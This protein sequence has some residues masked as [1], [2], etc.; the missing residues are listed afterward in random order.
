MGDFD[1]LIPSGG[2]AVLDA[3][4]GDDPFADLIPK[5]DDENPFGDLIPSQSSPAAQAAP[6]SPAPL[7]APAVRGV[8]DAGTSPTAVESEYEQHL[9][10]AEAGRAALFGPGSIVGGTLLAGQLNKERKAS[11]LKEAEDIAVQE[12]ERRAVEKVNENMG[13]GVLGELPQLDYP[14]ELAPVVTQEFETSAPLENAGRALL[15]GL[16]RGLP[17]IIGGG[18]GVIA[19]GEDEERRQIEQH[20]R[21]ML[22]LITK[23]DRTPFEER[24]L[25]SA[26]RRLVR[27]TSRLE[28]GAD[29]YAKLKEI[30][31]LAAETSKEAQTFFGQDPKRQEDFLTKF[32]AGAGSLPPYIASGMAGGPVLSM[33]TGALQTGQN[34]YNAAI[35]AGHPELANQAMEKGL[36]IGLT[37]GAGVGGGLS[38]ASKGFASKAFTVLKKSVEEGGQE[39]VQNTLSNLN[40]ST[41]TGYDPNRPT[42]KGSGEAAAIGFLLGGGVEGA[43]Q[44]LRST[45]PSAQPPVPPAE[46]PP[47]VPNAEYRGGQPAMITPA[48]Q[49]RM[50]AEAAKMEAAAQLSAAAEAAREVSPLAAAEADKLA[51]K[52]AATQLPSPAAEVTEASGETTGSA[53]EATPNE[54]PKTPSQH[55]GPAPVETGQVPAASEATDE[56]DAEFEALL[57]QLES[58]PAEVPT[59]TPAA[60]P[61]VEPAPPAAEALP[62]P[63]I[64]PAIASPEITPNEPAPASPG[65][66]GATGGATSVEST[67]PVSGRP[68][69]TGVV[70]ESAPAA[71]ASVAGQPVGA[72]E[73]VPAAKVEAPTKASDKSVRDHPMRGTRKGDDITVSPKYGLKLNFSASEMAG[74]TEWDRKGFIEKMTAEWDDQ[75]GGAG[76]AAR[77]RDAVR[78]VVRQLVP[79]KPSLQDRIDANRKAQTQKSPPEPTTPKTAAPSTQ[80]PSA[81][82]TSETTV[83]PAAT[84]EPLR[85]VPHGKRFKIV[86]AADEPMGKTYFKRNT[87]GTIAKNTDGTK[88]VIPKTYETKALAERALGK[89]G[90]R[91]TFGLPP[92]ANDNDPI[93]AILEQTSGKG[94]YLGNLAPEERGKVLTNMGV[95]ENGIWRNSL[96][97]NDPYFTPDKVAQL[98]A[99]DDAG[100]HGDGDERTMYDLIGQAI[101]SRKTL[102]DQGK[103]QQANQKPAEKQ[104]RSFER[105]VLTPKEGATATQ[106]SSLKTGDEVLVDGERLIVTDVDEDGTVTM[107]D[108]SK[109]GIQTVNEETVVYGEVIESQTDVLS[110]WPEIDTPLEPE[111]FAVQEGILN[112]SDRS[113]RPS[114]EEPQSPDAEGQG[115]AKQPVAEAGRV[116]SA[117]EKV[118]ETPLEKAR[119]VLVAREAE[120]AEARLEGDYEL[121]ASLERVLPKLRRD[122]AALESAPDEQASEPAEPTPTK[123]LWQ[124]TKEAAGGDLIAHREAVKKAVAEGKPVSDE[125]VEQYSPRV[126]ADKELKRRRREEK[127]KANKDVSIQPVPNKPAPFKG[128]VWHGS[129]EV[130]DTFNPDK[131]GQNTGSTDYAAGFYF[132]INRDGAGWGKN[133]NEWNVELKNPLHTNL[134]PDEFSEKYGDGDEARKKLEALGYDGVIANEQIIA[135]HTKQVAKANPFGAP[136]LAEGQNEADLPKLRPGKSEDALLQGENDVFNLVSET[137]ADK[138]ARLKREQAEEKAKAEKEAAEAK[139]IQEKQQQNLFDEGPQKS[140]S[141]KPPARPETL[142]AVRAIVKKLQARFKGAAETAVVS[143]GSFLP[144]AVIEEAR[145][146]GIDPNRIGGV[147]YN[148][149]VWLNAAGLATPQ[150]AVEVFFHEQAAHHGIDTILD[151]IDPGSS[152]KLGKALEK[153][154]P[155][156]WAHVA[157]RYAPESQISETLAR[158]METFGPNQT[159][160][161]AWQRVV[162]L[163][164]TVLAKAGFKTWSKNDVEALL[165]RGIERIR[166]RTALNESTGT[167]FSIE[168]SV[169][170]NGNAKYAN[171][172]DPITKAHS[173]IR[174]TGVSKS[175]AGRISAINRERMG[176]SE[177]A[178]AAGTGMDEDSQLLRDQSL[179]SPRIAESRREA[180]KFSI[181]DRPEGLDA[182]FKTKFGV[183]AMREAVKAM[184]ATWKSTKSG[185]QAREAGLASLRERVPGLDEAMAKTWVES[186]RSLPVET[187]APATKPVSEMSEEEISAKIDAEV[188]AKFAAE[189]KARA[190]RRKAE[191]PTSTKNAVMEAER[192]ARNA[193]PLIREAR[194]SNEETFD[195]ALAEIAA[196]SAIAQEIVDGLRDGSKKQV[197]EVDEAILLYEKV[198]IRNGRNEEAARASDPHATEESRQAAAKRWEEL[199]QKNNEIDQATRRSGSIWGRLGQFRQRLMAADFTFEALERK[200]RVAKQGPLSP[201]ESEK[202]RK[203]AAEHEQLQKDL[204][205]RNAELEEQAAKLHAAEEMIRALKEA[206]KGK[207]A[208]K[209]R[210]ASD[211]KPRKPILQTIIDGLNA[212]AIAARE[213]A[214]ARRAEGR[215]SANPVIEFADEAIWG[216]AKLAH[217]TFKFAK[218][219]SE[220]LAD[221]GDYLKPHLKE[222]W[223]AAKA[224]L[225]DAINN[226]PR[227]IAAERSATID[228][229]KA[230]LSEGDLKEE[231]HRYAR[232]LAKQ[233]IEEGITEL[234][235]LNAAV[236]GALQQAIP[237]ITPTESRDMWTGYG[238]F[239]PLDTDPVKVRL[240]ELSTEGQKVSTIERLQK[241]LAGARQPLTDRA[242]ALEKEIK[243][244]QKEHGIQTT[245]PAKQLKSTMDAI[246]SRLRNEIA[247]LDFA[248]S[249]GKRI[250]RGKSGVSYDAE[251]QSLKA[252]RDAKK[253]AYDAVFPKE[254]ITPEEQ[255]RRATVLAERSVE[256]WE[257]RLADARKGIFPGK[258]TKVQPTSDELKAL[259]LQREAAKAEVE[260]LRDM[261]SGFQETRQQEALQRAGDELQRKIDE[262]EVIPP[263]STPKAVPDSAKVAALKTRN[264]ALRKMLSDLREASGAIDARRNANMVRALEKQIAALDSRIKAGD[265]APRP[266]GTS[267]PVTPDVFQLRQER[268]AMTALV[269]TA[270]V[271]ELRAASKPKKSPEEIALQ[272]RKS[273]MLHRIAELAR[274]RLESDF[275]KKPKPPAIVLDAKGEKIELAMQKMEQLFLKDLAKYRKARRTTAKKILDG[276]RQTKDA[277]VNIQSSIDFS[278]PRQALGVILANTTRLVTN[279]AVGAR[280]LYNPFAR[281]FSAAFSEDR[282]R[283]IELRRNKRPNAKSGAYETSDVEFTDLDTTKFTKGEEAARSVLDEWA[284]RP[285][286]GGGI[287]KGAVTAASRLVR[288]SN[289]AFITFLNETRADL[290][291]ELLRANFQDRAPTVEEL[292]VVGNTVNIATGR[293]A[294]NPQH[295]KFASEILWSPKLLA[296]R[297]QFLTGQP[298]WG[299]AGREGS[300]RTQVMVAKE[301]ARVIAGG[302]V[303]LAVAKMF[304]D[305]EEDDPTSSDYGKIV[306]GN[307]RIDVWG[308]FQQVTTLANRAVRGKVKSINGNVR[309]ISQ[310]GFGN[311]AWDFMVNKV[312]P[313]IK[314]LAGAGIA[315]VDAAAGKEGE[316]VRVTPGEAA[317]AFIPVPLSLS[318]VLD[319]I[320]DRGV[321]EAMALQMMNTFGAGVN[322]YTNEQEPV[323]RVRP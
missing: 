230:R 17:D 63:Q 227:D 322:T 250:I 268:D 299:K 252:E 262:G 35:E 96:V 286:R 32:A 175:V 256:A 231:M 186:F 320:K 303:L 245:D 3:P 142:K 298:F 19:L 236:H 297:I 204:A 292:K 124:V 129:N 94:I 170:S 141:D 98:I 294:M 56:T 267:K 244:L 302:F 190:E 14:G 116:A 18:A 57:A 70:G 88:Q 62:P 121:A 83:Q 119:R 137:A 11:E 176:R 260:H 31:N 153:S 23:P 183:P 248:I 285:I 128:V 22:P 207:P 317:L 58:E 108:G 9:A 120:Q 242:R 258:T 305:K 218:W 241:K 308:G 272:V 2:T 301:Y 195:M 30:Q 300:L 291:D 40:A 145:A 78:N 208:P 138:A 222:L 155:N 192:A 34:E 146:K 319:A 263:E 45:P 37:E 178:M 261:D 104:A 86:N 253:E 220:M 189:E 287:A 213:R 79:P 200:A 49:A 127:K 27:M 247:D 154:F 113:D 13:A 203:L 246:K 103:A 174:G 166:S 111:E 225:D 61:P 106:A 1:D 46:P 173:L 168:D 67:P 161:A 202:Y 163:I 50:E 122:L 99:A 184:Q 44:L 216:A 147:Y 237:D 76:Q 65:E 81:V 73:S 123:E 75:A 289:R 277:Y 199:E 132:S 82:T 117:P 110:D 10:A 282:A 280:L 93:D 41:M 114:G 304:D 7:A 136:K 276:I 21:E 157:E 264:E 259:R 212:I 48:E 210:V 238:R 232:Q 24:S 159:R 214:R 196:N 321:P 233:F 139:S 312:R 185:N 315:A 144:D 25:A 80:Q 206:G 278:A 26:E 180:V 55:E 126:W 181:E 85:I 112:E 226:G 194:Q 77:L 279:P 296:S 69:G 251:A 219:S 243:K 66:S 165:R 135:F 89:I 28:N 171:E 288:G 205:E 249:T 33:L 92:S 306:R 72:A 29:F 197:S 217:G 221:F 64:E 38:A 316:D 15:G 39:W 51:A 182:A 6:L 234:E 187:P 274:K 4:E 240:R 311:V 167:K 188:N 156:E 97:G 158:I 90:K 148:G 266:V 133:V 16:A 177:A 84:S 150:R 310:Y 281:M 36:L 239:K 59:A 223:G 198:R 134:S 115:R 53:G 160:P 20:A 309:N 271:R 109:F 270:L 95:G 68:G 100:H 284:A 314:A 323:S 47:L 130:F 162:D 105:A 209:E 87:D 12:R 172:R 191:P 255:L 91:S 71:P 211:Y 140:L 275:E 143:D 228:G 43:N 54:P 265:F 293:G 107:K 164:R 118:A 149:V 269:M 257:K 125:V 74:M 229:I 313:D 318:G 52:I 5:A 101:A 283:A 60:T 152:A 8:S 254:P 290:V 179:T 273:R 42:F 295:A 307:T 169:D 131:I 224:K 201:E 235:P 215:V 102:R 151:G 193:D